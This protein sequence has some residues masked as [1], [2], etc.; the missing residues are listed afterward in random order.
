MIARTWRGAVRTA[1]R[2]AYADYLRETGV[3]A[4]AATP[5]NLGVR[6][7]RRDLGDRTEFVM[8]TFWESLEAIRAFA[9]E[10]EETAIFYPEDDGFLI[11]R[12][13][14]ALHYEV[15]EPDA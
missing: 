15:V 3:A 6:M 9:G 5:G 1:D 11:E 8:L 7:L 14:V 4:Y 13:A 10:D 12:D 2:D